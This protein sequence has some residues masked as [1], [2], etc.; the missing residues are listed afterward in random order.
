MNNKLS[1]ASVRI[2][3]LAAVFAAAQ[4]PVRAELIVG[5]TSQNTLI[6]FD[7]ATPGTISAPVSL[8]G[9]VA[10]DTLIGIDRRPSTGLLNGTLYSLG[11]N[12]GSGLGR[13]YTIDP[14]TGIATVGSTL[15]AD[16]ADTT[17]PFPFMT[18]QGTQFGFDFNPVPDRL[19]VV[20]NTGQNLRINVSNGLVQLDVALAYLA[21]DANFG[22][23]PCITAVAYSNN[24]GGASSTVLRGVDTCLSPDVLTT[25]SNPNAGTLQTQ[26]TLPFD[27]NGAL[28]GYDISGLTGTPYFSVTAGTSGSSSFYMGTSLVGTIGG[29]VSVM[30]IAA[31]VGNPV[32]EPAGVLLSGVGL[33]AMAVWR[34]RRQ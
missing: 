30:D 22:A 27:S 31:P 28:T 32:P 33:L 7:S 13:L 9:I 3:A 21:G 18:V 10:G 34:R 1:R 14:L 16:P 6:S 2:I 4:T 17:A 26:A 5:L 8:S 15:S 11:V 20:S 19:R 25:I 23:S 24:F 12:F 29:G